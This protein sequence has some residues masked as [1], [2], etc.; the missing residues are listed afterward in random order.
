MVCG[1]VTLEGY[2]QLLRCAGQGRGDGEAV[3]RG[4][5]RE[6]EREG[7]GPMYHKCYRYVN[8]FCIGLEYSNAVCVLKDWSSTLHEN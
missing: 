4:S 8:R 3:G 5:E 6:R 2:K 7:G 1:C